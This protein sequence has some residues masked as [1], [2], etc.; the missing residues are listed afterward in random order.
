MKDAARGLGLAIAL[1]VS[2]CK[3]IELLAQPH[4]DGTL[5]KSGVGDTRRLNGDLTDWV[6][7]KAHG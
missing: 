5:G 2:G 7:M 3:G 6:R 1:T 4:S